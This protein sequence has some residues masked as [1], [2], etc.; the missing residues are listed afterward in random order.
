MNPSARG[1]QGTKSFTDMHA[2][3]LQRKEDSD[4][5]ATMDTKFYAYGEE[6]ERVE[7]FKYLGRLI[8]FDD[9]DTHVVCGNLK[10]DRSTWPR[11]SRVPR[12]ENASPK[13]YGMFD[14]ATVQAVLL[15][16]SKTWNLSKL[17]LGSSRAST[18]MWRAA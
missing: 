15:Y 10:K 6:L 8:T 1:H 5:A 12:A 11:I 13:V 7:V 17:A 2:A 14:Q 4:S 18:F 9:D 16:G 3:K